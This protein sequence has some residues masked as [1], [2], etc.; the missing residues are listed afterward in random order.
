MDSGIFIKRR[1]N[2]KENA[3]TLSLI[4]FFYINKILSIGEKE[5]IEEDHLFYVHRKL[6]SKHLGNKLERIAERL[7]NK[8]KHL[9]TMKLLVW[10]CAKKYIYLSIMQLIVMAVYV[11]VSPLLLGKFVLF[12]S[13]NQTEVN[14]NGA[15]FFGVSY[16]ALSIIHYVYEQN[17]AMI[18]EELRI[19]FQTALCSLVYRKSLRLSQKALSDITIGKIVSLISK[20]INVF[21]YIISFGSDWCVGVIQI[22]IIVYLFYVRTGAATFV[23]FAMLFTTLPIQVYIARV[24]KVKRTYSNK[25]SDERLQ[26]TQEIL[27]SIRIIKMYTWEKFFCKRITA[28]RREEMKKLRQVLIFKDVSFLLGKFVSVLSFYML[29]SSYVWMGNTLSAELVFYLYSSYDHLEETIIRVLPISISQVGETIA[30]LERYDAFFNAQ[31]TTGNEATSIIKNPKTP[32]IIFYNVDVEIQ[33]NHVLNNIKLEMEPGLNVIVGHVGSGKSILLKT[34]L[35][36]YEVSRGSLFVEGKTSYASQFPWLFPST[37]K[38][39]ILFGEK[40]EEE[41]YN[42]ILDICAL[43]FDLKLLEFGD[44]TIIGDCGINLSKG[45]QARVNL[46]RALYK[47]S[48]IYLLD[49]CLS[50]LDPNVR[51]HIFT[52]LKLYLQGRIC[53]LATHHKRFIEEADNV[54]VMHAGTVTYSGNLRSI[55][56]EVLKINNRRLSSNRNSTYSVICNGTTSDKDEE[57]ELLEIEDRRI[58]IYHE[59]KNSGKVPID[60]YQKYILFGG[61]YLF[62]GVIVILLISG[63]SAMTY[64]KE[65]LS[66]WVDMDEHLNVLSK[67]SSRS[68]EELDTLTNKRAVAFNVYTTITI[69]GSAFWLMSLVIHFYF[70]SKISM[71]LHKSMIES[72]LGSTMEFFDTNLIGNILN[73]FSKDVYYIDE[74]LVYSTNDFIMIFV[75]VVSTATLISSISDVFLVSSIVFIVLFVLLGHVLL[76]VGRNLRRL[77]SSTRSPMV[78]HLN[79]TLEGIATVRAWRNHQILKDEFDS[80]QDL[81]TSAHHTMFIFTTG[82][83]LI[84]KMVSSIFMAIIVGNFLFVKPDAA[85]KV[86]LSLTQVSVLTYCLESCLTHWVQLE[87]EM[88]CFERALEY[89]DIKQEPKNGH[90][91]EK[92]PFTPTIEFRKV[93]L[94]Y[95]QKGKNV[96]KDVSFRIERKERAAIVGRTGAG[97]SSIIVALFRMYPIEGSIFID[98]MDT[99]TLQ[100][101]KLRENLTIIPQDP[102]L[103]TGSMRSNLDPYERYTDSEIWKAVREVNLDQHVTDLEYVVRDCGAHLSI[104]QRQLIC[105]ARALLDKHKIIILDE[106]TANMDEEMEALIHDTIEKHFRECTVISISHRLRHV[107]HYDKVLVMEEGELVEFGSPKELLKNQNGVFYSMAQKAHLV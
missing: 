91:V 70:A 67:N 26:L 6:R 1:R 7:K 23:G 48:D 58:N 76:P 65:L 32:K 37:I 18:K 51:R 19:E 103:F 20:D 49:D 79:A 11:V 96:L 81:F 28:A 72:V 66:Q 38:Q 42:R 94:S 12:F 75:T 29:I 33:G 56:Q 17:Y 80:H 87:S 8:E 73:R 46:A 24:I 50:S 55:P 95:G 47:E 74:E 22:M 77:N 52:S 93:C 104:G 15:C 84:L 68:T 86:G 89:T 44:K 82:F 10:F 36:E 57:S 5:D 45:Q 31:E 43:D 35:K 88:T 83:S 27:A 102:I 53:V 90:L 30:S 9:S 41:K 106:A 78:G 60:V 71:R 54:I 14:W 97:K 2:P 98:S 40:Y 4:T 64:G 25:K 13:P 21:G 39:N 92:W 85:G 61:G 99:Q 69:V 105:I 16:V 101:E 63:G 100:L 107:L 34:I 62:Y 3:N 59:N